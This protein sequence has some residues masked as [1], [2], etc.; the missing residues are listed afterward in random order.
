MK[1]TGQRWHIIRFNWIDST[2]RSRCYVCSTV[3]MYQCLFIILKES[4]ILKLG[5]HCKIDFVLRFNMDM[6]YAI[7]D[8]QLEVHYFAHL[9][10][11]PDVYV[12]PCDMCGILGPMVMQF[13]NLRGVRLLSSMGHLDHDDQWSLLSWWL[14]Q[15]RANSEPRIL[16]LFCML[17]TWMP[18]KVFF[19]LAAISFLVTSHVIHFVTDSHPFFAFATSRYTLSWRLRRVINRF[20]SPFNST[21]QFWPWKLWEILTEWPSDSLLHQDPHVSPGWPT[22]FAAAGT[23]RPLYKPRS[24]SMV[25]DSPARGPRPWWT[26]GWNFPKMTFF[27]V[28][29]I[30]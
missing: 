25:E 11:A 22:W 23:W 15:W 5:L 27:Q 14:V 26:Y 21:Y 24:R 4:N 19:K 17:V 9:V 7:C 6:T 3:Y 20:K 8:S 16:N 18:I 29:R 2:Q 1:A 10:M 12:V 28:L 30:A 13:R